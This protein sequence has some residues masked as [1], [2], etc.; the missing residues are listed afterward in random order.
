MNSR[1]PE[2]QR[3][4]QARHESERHDGERIREA[5]QAGAAAAKDAVKSQLNEGKTAASQA[6]RSTAEA[7]EEAA[8]SLAGQDRDSLARV[9]SSMAEQLSDLAK[10]L[11]QRS[12]DEL[13]RDARQ[14]ARKHPGL[15]IAGGVALGLAMGRFF[16]ASAQRA[17]SSRSES[18]IP[19]DEPGELWLP[20][21]PEHDPVANPSGRPDTNTNQ[22]GDS[23][24]D[25]R[26]RENRHE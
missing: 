13:T 22:P 4:D 24:G 12:L 26:M 8:S 14:L 19:E 23:P 15:F 3:R 2:H 20:D 21:G 16:R 9:A 11:E 25:Y 1:T 6:A 10:S 5:G 7:M 17:R 18:E